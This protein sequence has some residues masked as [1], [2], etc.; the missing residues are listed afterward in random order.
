MVSGREWQEWQ[1]EGDMEGVVAWAS[2]R[3]EGAPSVGL[4]AQRR[5][6]GPG[7]NAACLWGRLE[8]VPCLC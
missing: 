7:Q 2:W 1:E 5:E 6:A 8:V 3:W 4:R